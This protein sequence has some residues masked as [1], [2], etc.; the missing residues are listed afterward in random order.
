MDAPSLPVP[1][2]LNTT[3]DWFCMYALTPGIACAGIEE[4]HTHP[5]AALSGRVSTTSVDTMP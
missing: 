2:T 3:P 4:M 1:L 5:G